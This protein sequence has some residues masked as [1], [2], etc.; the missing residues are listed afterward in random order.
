MPVA[1]SKRPYKL[2]AAVLS[3][4]LAQ[5]VTYAADLPVAVVIIATCV[6]AGLAVYLTPNPIIDEDIFD[7][8]D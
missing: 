5:L 7:E 2:Y 8:L 4:M 3:A 6:I 1:D